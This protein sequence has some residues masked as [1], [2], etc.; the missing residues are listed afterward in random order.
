M[1]D[2]LRRFPAA[3]VDADPRL[4]LVKAWVSALRGREDDD[5]RRRRAVRALG[6]LDDGPLPDGFAS[7]ESSL[8]GAQRDVRLGRRVGDP[9]ARHALGGARGARTRRGGR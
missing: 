1:L 9:R 7:L 8:V 3:V 5:A 2:W 6:G 4:L